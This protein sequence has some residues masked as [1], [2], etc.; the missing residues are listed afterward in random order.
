LWRDG[1]REEL[2]TLLYGN[3]TE[4]EFIGKIYLV[5]DEFVEG[6]REVLKRTRK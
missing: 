1:P 2:R 4:E 5:S 3:K 6:T